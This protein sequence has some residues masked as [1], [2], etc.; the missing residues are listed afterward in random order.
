MK[1]RT[2]I[3]LNKVKRIRNSKYRIES[4]RK[5][6]FSCHIFLMDKIKE[7]RKGDK[8]SWKKNK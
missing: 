1:E 4:K 5:L 8:N 6:L 2:S 7:V 3:E